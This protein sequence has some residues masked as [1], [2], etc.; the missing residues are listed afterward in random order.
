MTDTTTRPRRRRRLLAA[1]LG[2]AL[3][4]GCAGDSAARPPAPERLPV[5]TV[6][7]GGSPW[8]VAADGEGIWVSDFAGG[9]V[10][11]LAS[12]GRQ[13]RE[14]ALP[15]PDPRTGGLVLAEGALWVTQLGAGVSTLALPAAG[16]VRSAAGL[17]EVA[18]VAVGGGAAWLAG[19]GPGGALVQL[20]AV[21]LARRRQVDLP[22]SP[23]QVELAGA[24]LWVAG[25]D[26]RLF[27]L[28]AATGEVRSEV[29]VG[30]A[31]RGLAVTPDAVWVAVRDT[32]SLVRVDPSGRGAPRQV[33]VGGRP[34][35]VAADRDEVWVAR[36]DG[37]LVRVDART[38]QVTHTTPVPPGARG[39]ALTPSAAWVTGADGTVSR[40]ARP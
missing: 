12:D 20:D 33:S 15:G 13:L 25:L 9:R 38:L 21:S 30:A 7:V 27:R 6:Q 29:P 28:D 4:A 40:V 26:A 32:G 24:D 22:E 23:F 18:D 36:Q 16:P 37:V 10:L 11:E 1:G 34:W 35:P 3:L 39:L 14:V 5:R 2:A 8:G 31:P 19:H 17:G